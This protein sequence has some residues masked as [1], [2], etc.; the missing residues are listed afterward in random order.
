MEKKKLIL[1][2]LSCAVITK[3]HAAYQGRVYVDS[4]RNGIYDKGEKVL[5]GIRV[6]DGLN[7]VKTN[8]EGVYA[9]PGHERERFIFITTPSGYRTDNQY[10]RRING[11]G[12]TY[13]F[14]LQPWKGRIKPNGSHRFI[15]ISDT[16]IF[17]TENQ[18]DWAN[19]I[20]DYAAN[21]NIAFIIHTGDICYEN[22]LKNHIHLMNTSN[23]D[24][25]MF[26]CIGNHDLV[27]GKY[28]EEVF[29]NV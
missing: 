7:V 14:G 8:A 13:D 15:H 27:K 11:T 26:Y 4:N 3:A 6:S 17:N 1:L 2:L 16:E 18:E 10:Y 20:R 23:M 12:Q 28:G 21:E 19:N 9:L 24:C 25:P 29:E 5:K 22:G